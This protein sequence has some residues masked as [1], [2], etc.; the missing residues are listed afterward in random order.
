[1]NIETIAHYRGHVFRDAEIPPRYFNFM[2]SLK[3]EPFINASEDR[4]EYCLRWRRPGAFPSDVGPVLKCFI[5]GQAKAYGLAYALA[6]ELDDHP[7]GDA[8][9]IS[10]ELI[11]FICK[12]GA[13]YA[14]RS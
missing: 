14:K 9:T 3:R 6:C 13:D 8:S 4:R 10:V 7:T 5:V 2:E 11:G 12:A 1:M